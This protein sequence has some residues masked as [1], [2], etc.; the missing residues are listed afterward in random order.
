MK[1]EQ[2]I[3]MRAMNYVDDDIIVAAHAPNKK[4]RRIIKP[5][6]A[7]CLC[8]VLVVSFPY[9]RANIN[10]TKDGAEDM[11]I[12]PNNGGDDPWADFTWNCPAEYSPYEPQTL[13][14]TTIRLTEWTD[15]TV[16]FIIQK[17]DSVPIYAAF[18]Q[19]YTDDVLGCTEPN[20]RDGR[21]YVRPYAVRVYV[22]GG[23]MQYDLP[24]EPGKYEVTLDFSVIW[25]MNLMMRGGVAFYSYIGVGGRPVNK[26]WNIEIGGWYV[27]ES[28]TVAEAVTE[29]LPETQPETN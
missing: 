25:R 19:S 18:L 6:I 21:V 15:T 2:E 11:P 8:V 14:G 28:D 12:E 24:V 22:D 29:T 10:L 23:E 26:W 3:L 5:L 1:R 17:T 9:L 4:R 7:A 16:T 20:F 13:G 27:P